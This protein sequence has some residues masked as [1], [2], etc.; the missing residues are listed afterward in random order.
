M[1][2]IYKVKDVLGMSRAM[3]GVGAPAPHEG[4]GGPRL[5]VPP[6]PNG[7][8]SRSSSTTADGLHTVPPGQW[9][10]E[11][12][13]PSKCAILSYYV[14]VAFTIIGMIMIIRAAMFLEED[15]KPIA[16]GVGLC[17]ATGG[18]ALIAITNVITRLEH[19]KIMTY[20]D[21]KVEELRYHEN[22][23][24]MPNHQEASYLVPSEES[25]A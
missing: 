1:R 18:I 19:E 13:K 7:P 5:G 16:L 12:P 17:L 15:E 9:P 25:M 21:M 20:L 4:V 22:F 2:I 14:S 24:K 6:A 23:R 11:G 3:G 8:M 10:Q